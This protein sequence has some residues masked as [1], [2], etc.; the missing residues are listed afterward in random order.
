MFQPALQLGSGPSPQ[1]TDARRARGEELPGERTFVAGPL[2]LDLLAYVACSKGPRAQ[3]LSL[4]KSWTPA[5]ILET[6]LRQ[7]VG[8]PAMSGSLRR[9]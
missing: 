8:F 3:T 9:V 4:I 1:S 5:Q 2:L 7:N 6:G